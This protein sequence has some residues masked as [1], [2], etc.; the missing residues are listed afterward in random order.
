[1]KIAYGAILIL[2]LIWG[3]WLTRTFKPS[4]SSD[5]QLSIISPHRIITSLFMH[6]KPKNFGK[7]KIEY[8]LL[9][10]VITILMLIIDF[11]DPRAY[12]DLYV[13]AFTFFWMITSIAYK[14]NPKIN[15]YMAAFFLFLI[16]VNRLASFI[17]L[18]DKLGVWTIMFIA[19]IG[20]YSLV[21]DYIAIERTDT[22][23]MFS[24]KVKQDIAYFEKYHNTI[25]SKSLWFLHGALEKARYWI[26]RIYGMKNKTPRDWIA[27]WI[28]IAI[29][30]IILSI[31]FFIFKK[32][33]SKINRFSFDPVVNKVE[34]SIIYPSTKVI[35]WG[36]NF[37]WK[38][39]DGSILQNQYGEVQT[40]VWTNN[41]IIF[42]APLSWPTGPMQFRIVKPSNYEGRHIY[43]ASKIF[44]ILLIPRGTEFTPIDD[45]FFKQLKDLDPETRRINGY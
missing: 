28:K 13:V 16:V 23:E 44:N 5:S 27:L 10:L 41:K 33:D 42:E 22:F 9:V 3:T 34:P 25:L 11:I 17:Y 15:M 14:L 2:L 30:A 12:H 24:K 6:F 35:I 40:E 36:D 4:G 38:E 20:I 18:A 7:I 37:G 26:I 8:R 31:G 43:A 45:E 19:Y 29:T 21:Y 39:H 32:V 1:M